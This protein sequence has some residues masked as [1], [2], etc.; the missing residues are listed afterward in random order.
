MRRALLLAAVAVALAAGAGPAGAD[1]KRVY[2]VGEARGFVHDSIPAAVAFFADLGRRDRRF[3]VVPLRSGAAGLTA[4]R[5]RSADAVVFAT[6]SGEL[7][8]PDRAAFLRFV[9]GGGGFV[10]THSASDTLHSWPSYESL[11][12]G[13]FERH[14][15]PETGRL[16]VEAR[17]HPITRGLPRSF[18]LHEEFYEFVSSP[19]R[20]ARILVSLDPDSVATEA[21]RDV[22][23]VWARAHARGRVFYN[24]LGHFPDTWRHPV[25]R[26]LTARGLAWV[27]RL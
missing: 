18:V 25:H 10:G 24:A 19:R 22:P 9:R 5:L 13:E 1:P 4:R 11:L 21:G 17:G 15:T 14:G 2:V 6:T 20:R 8:L 16:V 7:A 27:L 23:M 26:R 3:D 12:G